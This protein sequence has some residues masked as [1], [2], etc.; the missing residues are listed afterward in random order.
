MQ[1]NGCGACLGNFAK[2]SFPAPDHCFD[3]NGSTAGIK[4]M[5]IAQQMLIWWRPEGGGGGIGKGSDVRHF[6]MKLAEQIPLCFYTEF[7]FALNIVL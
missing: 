5:R 6:W 3:T 1:R 7:S 2:N 4:I